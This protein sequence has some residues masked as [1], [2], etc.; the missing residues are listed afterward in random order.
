MT[1]LLRVFLITACILGFT[2]GLVAPASAATEVPCNSGPPEPIQLRVHNGGDICFGGSV[3]VESV[4]LTIA[5]MDSGGY[6][7][8]LFIQ[9]HDQCVIQ[10]FRR[11]S[12]S[13]VNAIV[14]AIEIE[15][16]RQ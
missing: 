13:P 4:G 1:T 2:A 11:R 16:R 14:G 9:A 6:Y 15:P 5:F 7:G 12:G 10:P 3:G 8:N